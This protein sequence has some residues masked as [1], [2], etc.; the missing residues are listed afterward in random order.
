[1]DE[2]D[3]SEKR[4][5]LRNAREIPW[6]NIQNTKQIRIFQR[7]LSYLSRSKYV[8]AQEASVFKIEA[9]R[10][11]ALSPNWAYQ[12][13]EKEMFIKAALSSLQTEL[14][15]IASASKCARRH[16]YAFIKVCTFFNLVYLWVLTVLAG[17]VCFDRNSE[18]R[19]VPSAASR[20]R[21][22]DRWKACKAWP[23][24]D[25][26]DDAKLSLRD[27][28]HWCWNDSKVQHR[29]LVPPAR[30]K[31]VDNIDPKARITA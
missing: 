11:T 17:W 21:N 8:D 19:N 13:P 18:T 30:G 27:N 4:K 16:T 5:H 1:M 15:K 10:D 25:P 2:S 9:C 23:S 20:P 6:L 12:C 31:L 14:D 28:R 3:G 22:H 7:L 29:Q 26:G 24:H